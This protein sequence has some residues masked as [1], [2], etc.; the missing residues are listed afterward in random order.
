V[1]GE[2]DAGSRYRQAIGRTI[3]AYRTQQGH[4]LRAFAESSGI[5]L[6]YLSELE[7]GQKEPSGAMLHQLANAFG[8]TVP[9]MLRDIA[10]H[11]EADEI[12]SEIS[13]E[14]LERDEIA[15]VARFTEWLRWR[16]E[17]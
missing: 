2:P 1:N 17:Q 7:H 9:Q 11:L 10:E 13:L 16:K 5:S 8:I 14:G 3:A 12:N 6:A 4:S 15:E